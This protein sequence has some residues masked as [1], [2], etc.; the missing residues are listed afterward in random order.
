MSLPHS[1][2][3]ALGDGHAVFGKYYHIMCMIQEERY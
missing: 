1:D 2:A 3:I